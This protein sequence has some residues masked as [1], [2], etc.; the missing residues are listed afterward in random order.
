MKTVVAAAALI[1]LGIFSYQYGPAIY[2][3]LTAKAT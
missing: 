2:K 1:A 3:K